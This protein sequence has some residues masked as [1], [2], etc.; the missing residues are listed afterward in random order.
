MVLSIQ[1]V[2]RPG[3]KS[4]GN[5]MDLGKLRSSLNKARAVHNLLSLAPKTVKKRRARRVRRDEDE[6]QKEMP[7]YNSPEM[8]EARRQL[9]VNPVVLKALKQWWIATD[10]DKSG[11]IDR[12]EYVELLK[13][14]Y[15]VKISADDE[16]DCQRCAE[17]DT[18]ED[19]EGITV[20]HRDRFYDGIF[21]LADL[22]TD[23]LN[24]EDC[25]QPLPP[26]PPLT[27]S[28]A[29]PVRLFHR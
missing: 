6:E 24:P 15:R 28:P 17:E 13:A 18:V 12:C 9:K 5:T 21:Q 22:W 20:M 2:E 3:A 19:F 1:D 7:D 4:G 11:E 27:P 10:E 14:I 8:L 29:S 16:E 23:T 26:S 25:T